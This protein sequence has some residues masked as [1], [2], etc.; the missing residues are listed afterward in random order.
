MNPHVISDRIDRKSCKL[1]RSCEPTFSVSS[2]KVVEGQP[3]YKEVFKKFKLIV[4]EPYDHTGISSENW[5]KEAAAF[6]M[7]KSNETKT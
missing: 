1:L 5:T 7:Q 6:W 4:P 2:A 3:K